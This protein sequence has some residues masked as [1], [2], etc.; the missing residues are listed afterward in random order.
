MVSISFYET[1]DSLILL[2][3]HNDKVIESRFPSV[4]S[5]KSTPEPQNRFVDFQQLMHLVSMATIRVQS[6][7]VFPTHHRQGNVMYM[8]RP[9]HHHQQIS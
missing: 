4:Y 9:Y 6:L 1:R 7:E 2:I 8:N 5:E 3:N